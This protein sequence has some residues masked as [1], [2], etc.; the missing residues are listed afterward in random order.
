MKW[1]SPLILYDTINVPNLP[2]SDGMKLMKC[3]KCGHEW[4]PRFERSIG[5]ITEDGTFT[6]ILECPNCGSKDNKPQ[7]V[8][9]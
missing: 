9:V 7:Q 4:S 1:I 5:F 8:I 2:D 6:S 3:E